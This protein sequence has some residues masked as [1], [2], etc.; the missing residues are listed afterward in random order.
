MNLSISQKITG[1]VIATLMAL[2]LMVA[3]PATVSADNHPASQAC[4]GVVLTGGTCDPDGAE[5]GITNVVSTIID[6]LSVIVGAVSVIMIIIGGFRYVT[7]AGDSNATTA[8]RNTI[9]YALV[10]LV[11][12]IFAQVI[13]SFVIGQVDGS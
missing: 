9:I 1:V 7:S 6:V 11:I 13:V 4:D 2:G 3:V 8:A 10:G 5:T 12:V